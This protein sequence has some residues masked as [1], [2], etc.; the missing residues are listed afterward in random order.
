MLKMLKKECSNVRFVEP[1][2]CTFASFLQVTVEGFE[3]L[4]QFAYTSKLPFTKENIHAIHRSAEYLGFRNLESACFD[5]LIPKFSGG[6]KNV[7]EVRRRACC[8]DLDSVVES[9]QTKSLEP[10]SSVP[11][12]GDEP[13]GF[14]SQSSQSAEC[15]V[16]NTG[17]HFCLENCGPQMPPL[18]LELP[19]GGV[20]PMLSLPCP[21]SNKA[22]HP[23]RFCTR[24]ILE[25]GD[26]CA[27]SELSL[28]DCALACELS[29]TGEIRPQKHIDLENGNDK[30]NIETLGAETNCNPNSCPLNA[31]A[32][33]DCSELIGQSVVCPEERMEDDLSGPT[34][35]TLGHEQEFGERSSV[36]REVAE[37]LAKGLWSNLCP[38]QTQALSLDSIDQNNLS[39]ASDFHWLKQLDLSASV[40][41]CPFFK[42]LESGNEQAPHTDEMSHSEKS[43]CM[44]SS[45][46]SGEDSELDTDGDTEANNIRA[47]EVIFISILMFGQ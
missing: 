18:S 35:T 36:E 32:V 34:L 17:E 26:V 43:P 44:S 39:K 31:S 25:I 23:S 10:H 2:Q 27:Q 4:L 20:C 1:H 5:F 38:S 41:D 7:Q 9:S 15:Q 16:N 42:D 40:G 6:K 8:L 24:D 46:N 14:P 47:A 33:A 12:R 29:N 37:H 28:A 13:T 11:S 21:E 22:N 30:Q 45:L 19:A 3:P